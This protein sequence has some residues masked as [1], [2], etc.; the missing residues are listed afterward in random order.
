MSL[1]RTVCLYRLNCKRNK[2]IHRGPDVRRTVRVIRTEH[3]A[4]VYWLQLIP[5]QTVFM[6]HQNYLY[7]N[8]PFCKYRKLYSV[9]VLFAVVD[10]QI[11]GSQR[12]QSRKLWFQT[13]HGT[14][15]SLQSLSPFASSRPS[16]LV[17]G[18][19]VFCVNCLFLLKSKR[20]NKHLIQPA[21]FWNEK[22]GPNDDY[23][24]LSSYSWILAHAERYKI[25]L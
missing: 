21:A 14:S 22:F 6:W 2:L 10:V 8:V 4:W 19:V 12:G 15:N 23:H 3:E 16:S 9:L 11:C 18:Y 20:P 24:I 13:K 5:A 1:A 25:S 7:I 17:C